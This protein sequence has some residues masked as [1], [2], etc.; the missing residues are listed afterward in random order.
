MKSM[1]NCSSWTHKTRHRLR[2]QHLVGLKSDRLKCGGHGRGGSGD[3]VPTSFRLN[4]DTKPS[5]N[6]DYLKTLGSVAQI[7]C[8][9]APR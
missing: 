6:E 1:S 3:S 8:C 2:K 7:S 4:L 9:A 5:S